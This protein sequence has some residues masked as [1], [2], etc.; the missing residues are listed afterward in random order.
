MRQSGIKQSK[1]KQLPGLKPIPRDLPLGFGF[2][3]LALSFFVLADRMH[4][5]GKLHDVEEKTVT[6]MHCNLVVYTNI[7]IT[8]M[9]LFISVTIVIDLL[10]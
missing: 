4:P 7:K 8:S 10:Q 6:S 3:C 5:T 1:N 2:D 9:A